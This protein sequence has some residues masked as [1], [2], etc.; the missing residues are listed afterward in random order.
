MFLNSAVRV[1]SIV[2]VGADRVIAI[3]GASPAPSTGSAATRDPPATSAAP[4]PETIARPA[5][6]TSAAGSRTGPALAINPLPVARATTYPS[7]SG[8]ALVARDCR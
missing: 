7:T 5:A 8:A 1:C 4:T 3:T 2:V 6:S